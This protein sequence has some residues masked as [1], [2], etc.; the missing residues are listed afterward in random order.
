MSIRDA[1][2]EVDSMKEEMQES[3][4]CTA[5]PLPVV[6]Q[7]DATPLCDAYAAAQPAT[8]S[9]YTLVESYNGL[10]DLA[11]ELERNASPVDAASQ[12]NDA[13]ARENVAVPL[14]PPYELLVSMAIRYDH[15][16]GCPGYYDSFP[17]QLGATHKQRLDSTI[18]VMRQLYEEVVGKGF[19]SPERADY[20]RNIAERA[21]PEH[22]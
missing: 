16:L 13:A 4:R 2:D 8:G 3:Q 14:E 12:I 7:S 9:I 6:P 19:Y 15:G 1:L 11:R 22:S 20:Y 5:S 18:S 10:L 17:I 21:A